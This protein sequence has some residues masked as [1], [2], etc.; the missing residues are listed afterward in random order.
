MRYFSMFFH[1]SSSLVGEWWW[2]GDNFFHNSRNIHYM[3]MKL[4]PSEPYLAANILKSK[5]LENV[6][7]K[8]AQS[9]HI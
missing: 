5:E 4:C 9:F 8:L 1:H 2:G 7:S 6:T 3:R